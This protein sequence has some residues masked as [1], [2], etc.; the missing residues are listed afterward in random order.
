VVCSEQLN[1]KNY[2]KKYIASQDCCISYKVHTGCYFRLSSGGKTIAMSFET[3]IINGGLS[4]S[5]IFAQSV[6]KKIGLSLAYGIVS[7]NKRVTYITNEVLT[8]KHDCVFEIYTCN[9]DLPKRLAG[10][11]LYTQRCSAYPQKSYLFYI[12]YC[13]KNLTACLVTLIAIVNRVS[14]TVLQV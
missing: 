1:F 10:C 6:L 9:L 2:I 4:S 3:K 14:K 7:I 11:K 8:S 5:F 12:L 13:T